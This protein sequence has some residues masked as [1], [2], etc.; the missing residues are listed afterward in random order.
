[1]KNGM[2]N[3]L[4]LNGIQNI[5]PGAI[6]LFFCAAIFIR[7]AVLINIFSYS[8]FPDSNLY[9]N[10]GHNLFRTW[11]ISPLVTFPYPLLNSLVNSF[12]SPSILLYLQGVITATAGGIFV[13][14][15]AKHSR[16][17]AIIFGVLFLCDLVWGAFTRSI[18]TD[19]L[20]AALTLACLAL[21]LD[22]Y[23]RRGSIEF[24]G[25]FFSGLLYGL[26]L[27]FRP[28]NVFLG[29][30]I[31][32]LYV[33]LVRSWKKNLIQIMGASI[34]LLVAG[35][36][37]LVGS[38]TFYILSGKDSY[39]SSYTAFPLF[40]YKLFSP[41]NGPNSFKLNQYLS[42]CYPG[43]DLRSRVDRSEGGAVD[44]VNNMDLLLKGIIPCVSNKSEDSATTQTIFPLA[45]IESLVHAPTKFALT[46]YQENAVFFQYNDPYILRWLLDAR[47]N[48]GCEG[49][50]WCG[51]IGVSNLVWSSNTWYFSLYEKIAT[52]INQVYLVPV[53]IISL[54]VPEKDYFPFNVA[55]IGMGLL[56]ILIT[57]GRERFLVIVTF[58]ILQYTSITVIAGLGFT[59]RYAA[60][61]SPLQIILSGILYS[62][63]I[64]KSHQIFISKKNWIK[65]NLLRTSKMDTL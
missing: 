15:V 7:N 34:I 43:V 45:Y 3:K 33:F 40:I 37:N 9:I 64:R 11:H 16:L 27:I 54:L 28:S 57:K 17:L 65:S 47:N 5:S 2:V 61:M 46:M 23:D 18:L 56:L 26:T 39:T 32:P 19:S 50:S 63:M 55:W 1:M 12:Q 13:Y 60:M 38:G 58:T 53:G 10:L 48:Y 6:G 44:S 14:V 62:V 4:H 51:N 21:L 59:E 25:I 8:F 49:M 29:I 31:V 42:Q 52:K 41:E 36:I 35:L 24:S 20:F 22:H 30:L